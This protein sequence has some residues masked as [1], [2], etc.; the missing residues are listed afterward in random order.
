MKYQLF[1]LLLVMS[2]TVMAQNQHPATNAGASY[3]SPRTD[4]SGTAI[5]ACGSITSPGD[6]YLSKDLACP[7]TGLMV[8]GPGIKLNL[9]GHTITYGTAGG[10][11]QSVFGIENDACWDTEQ[12]VRAVPCDNHGAGIAAEVYGGAIVQSTNAPTFSD[13]LFFGENENADQVIISSKARSCSNTIRFM[14]M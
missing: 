3:T 1:I 5:S 6:Y 4:L 13:A 11:Q 10:A 12:R 8:A 7:G 9:N 2:G 14:T